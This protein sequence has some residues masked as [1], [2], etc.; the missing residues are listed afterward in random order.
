M[1]RSLFTAKWKKLGTRIRTKSAPALAASIVRSMTSRV[2]GV[3]QLVQREGDVGPAE[4]PGDLAGAA[5]EF[6]F[7]GHGEGDGF[8]AGAGED[9]CLRC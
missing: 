4:L 3:E 5:D 8:P 2:Q 6:A 9:D 7:L 1:A